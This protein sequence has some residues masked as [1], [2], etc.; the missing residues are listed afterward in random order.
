M[1]RLFALIL[2]LMFSLPLYAN[3]V[4]QHLQQKA[5]KGD[6]EAQLELAREY[7]KKQDFSSAIIWYQKAAQQGHADALFLLGVSQIKGQ[8]T[9]V[10]Q[11][12]GLKNIRK[13]ANKGQ[14]VAQF[15]LGYLYKK[16][17]IKSK[18]GKASLKSANQWFKLSADQALPV[19]QVA[20]GTHYAKGMGVE[21]D[22]TQAATWFRKAY[23]QGNNLAGYNLATLFLKP[24]KTASEHKRGLN[25]LQRTAENH[26]ALSQIALANLYRK[27]SYGLKQDGGKAI[28][29]LKQ[30]AENNS[31]LAQ[32]SLGAI[33][34]KGELVPANGSKARYWLSQAAGKGSSIAQMSL[35][36]ALI[37]GTVLPRDLTEAYIWFSLA[38]TSGNKKSAKV[39][40]Q[41]A[42]RLTV[43]QLARAQQK[44][45]E[46]HQ[47]LK[48]QRKPKE[49]L[50]L[51]EMSDEESLMI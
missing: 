30:A 46:L 7:G 19:A 11:S 34:L 35:G 10:N 42:S 37:K 17:V 25:I 41:L 4:L 39:R 36:A 51:P 20:L 47:S 9:Q 13:A 24:K 38:A 33:Y 26:H 8:G 18:S 12:A 6:V 31:S 44:A 49:K 28:H 23:A 29:W 40:D 14:R 48:E 43:E 1:N 21:K 50:I 5:Q 16:G 45:G 2:T 32:L 27:G 3:D 15:T 22:L